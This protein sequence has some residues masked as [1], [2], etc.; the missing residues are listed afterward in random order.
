MIKLLTIPIVFGFEIEV[1]F[2][3]IILGIPIYLIFRWFF[4]KRIQSVRKRRI[5]TWLATIAAAPL[6]YVAIIIIWTFCL[7]YYPNRDFDHK[8]WLIDKDERYE[9]VKDIVNS[10]ML[11]GKTKTQ[12]QKILGGDDNTLESDDWYYDLGFRP[13]LFNID[14]DNLEIAFKE[15]KVISVE[16]HKR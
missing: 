4:K 13:E 7:E 8:Q 14:P 15:G 5:V 1:Y 6:V 9:F 11:I 12:V 10:K 16:W 2:I 3:V